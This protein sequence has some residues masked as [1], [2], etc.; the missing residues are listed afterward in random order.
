M[1]LFKSIRGSFGLFLRDFAAFAGAKGVR[2]CVFI[3]LG[4]FV[5][6]IGL[7][8]LLPFVTVITDTDRRSS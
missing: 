7:V 5:E 4:G 6:G 1:P 3:F 2:A 8:L